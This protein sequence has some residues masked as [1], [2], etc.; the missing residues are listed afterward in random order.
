MS[1]D[2]QS[3]CRTDRDGPN[4]TWAQY[5]ASAARGSPRHCKKRRSAQQG[6]FPYECWIEAI[7]G[8][9]DL[10]GEGSGPIR[11]CFRQRKRFEI[12]CAHA[13]CNVSGA[14]VPLWS[15]GNSRAIDVTRPVGVSG[16]LFK[17]IDRD[18]RVEQNSLVALVKKG[19]SLA[20]SPLRWPD[21][22]H[23][24]LK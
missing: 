3:P 20:W 4:H 6:S 14:R 17:M 24:P 12:A 10:L 22:S 19:G 13:R 23:G 1:V 16:I 18:R 21:K 5:S 8:G 9:L 11:R 2:D 15:A 7:G